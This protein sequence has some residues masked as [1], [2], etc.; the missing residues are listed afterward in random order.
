MIIKIK[1]FLKDIIYY[2]IGG[3]IY[4]VAVTVFLSAN[5]ISPGG[6][7]GIATA[8]NYIFSTP[9]GAVVFLI[10]VPLFIIA[11][12]KLGKGF[13]VKTAV[14]TAIVS[15]LLD[16]LAIVLPEMKIDLILASIFGGTLMGLGV[17]IIMLRGSSTGGVEIVAKLVSIKY[18]YVSIGRLMLILDFSVVVTSAFIYKNVESALYS[19]VAL[20]ACSK[21]MDFVL[22]GADRGKVIYIISDKAQ[23][24]VCDILNKIGR[25]ATYLNVEG[26]YTGDERQM[27]M[28]TVRRNEVHNVYAAVRHYDKAAFVVVCEAGE[29]LG[30]GF[31]KNL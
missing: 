5:E 11:F 17:S 27:I 26:A 13:I 28:C 10:N 29:I 14:A 6:V 16:S 21:I 22:Y 7:T 2:I 20:Y 25:G 4:S 30:E 8:L 12:L 24:I 9:I 3:C 1:E 23:Y 19:T 18:P 15:I 31:K